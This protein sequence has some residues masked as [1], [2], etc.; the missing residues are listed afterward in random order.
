MKTELRVKIL[1]IV[2][3]L[4]VSERTFSQASLLK[5]IYVGSGNSNS[6][7]ILDMDSYG[8]FN[9]NDNINGLEPWITDG[10]SSGTFLLKDIR[11][12]LL[13]SGA[14]DFTKVNE[15]AFFIAYTYLEGNELWKTNGTEAGT[16]LVKDIAVGSGSPYL[17]NLTNFNGELFFTADLDQNNTQVIWKSDGTEQG[18][19]PIKNIRPN[20][21][22]SQYPRVAL[23][24]LT[25]FGRMFF[26]ASDGIH[27]QEL[28]VSDGT[29]VGTQ[30]VKDIKT[31]SLDSQI[32]NITAINDVVYFGAIGDTGTYSLWRS[33]GTEAGTFVVV[34]NLILYDNSTSITVFKD[35][36]YFAGQMLG[37]S[38][39]AEL[40]VSDGTTLGTFMVKD[41]NPGAYPS[42]PTSFQIAGDMLFFKADTP[43]YGL[44]PWL[45]DG[46]ESGTVM[47]KDINPGASSSLVS[48]NI[49]AS[50]KAVGNNL[51]F[52]AR[53]GLTIGETLWGSDGTTAGTNSIL[54][55]YPNSNDNIAN[56]TAINNILLFRAATISYGSELW[57]LDNTLSVAAYNDPSKTKVYPNPVSSVLTIETPFASNYKLQV[58]NQLGQLVLKQSQNAS[59]TSIDVSTLS[60]GLY[61]LNIAGEDGETQTI[62]FIKN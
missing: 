54:D 14:H 43:D 13:G 50:F 20:H 39:G 52:S 32:I 23:F 16:V 34:Q 27:G 48:N 21:P 44:E 22:T 19:I 56:I 35:K 9:A 2:M 17:N 26:I 33:D 38:T 46:T 59:S 62:K 57:R 24:T 25:N 31:G 37:G 5:D 42:A 29:E 45:T 11:T 41:I 58:I 15:L 55:L 61:F 10:T 8:I 60:K 4:F 47:V 28:W 1:I 7:E 53:D 40:W 12:G 18:T 6:S 49:Y 30:M 3:V 36:L 51:Y